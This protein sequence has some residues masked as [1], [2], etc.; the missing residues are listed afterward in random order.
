MN[1][2]YRTFLL[3]VAFVIFG[4]GQANS[5]IRLSPQN[6]EKLIIEKP[7]PIYPAFA[8]VL[9][10][11]QV[12]TVEIT[13]SET[14]IVTSSKLFNGNPL[15]RQ[16]ALEAA[17]KRKYKPYLVAGKPTPFITTVELFFTLGSTKDE[18][19]YDLKISQP[20]F[21]EYEKCSRLIR[22]QKWIEAENICKRTVQLADQFK[23]GRELERSGAYEYVGLVMLGQKRHQEAIE[24]FNRAIE[25]VTP[26]LD[27]TDA[28]LGQLFGEL[29]IA[30][31][32]LGDLNKARELYRRAEKIYQAAYDKFAG[33]DVDEEVVK[34]RQGYIKALKKLYEFHLIAAEDAGA[35]SEVEEIKKQMNSLP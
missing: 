26:K 24:Y 14:G 33:D 9:K 18:Y 25:I 28:E 2:A 35:T 16:A 21:E 5:Q 1:L 11:E 29:A 32:G 30:Y 27:E 3:F 4:S 31:Y 10:L 6:A 12:V 13:V 20:F 22:S 7:E 15:F 19:E 23:R 8:K 34:M 17:K